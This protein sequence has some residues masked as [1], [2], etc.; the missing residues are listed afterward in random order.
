MPNCVSCGRELPPHG[1]PDNICPE[2]RAAA[3]VR[4]YEQARANRRVM[5]S[6]MLR[7][8]PVT[9]AIIGANILVYLAMTLSGVS[10]TDPQIP[11]LVK[12]GANNGVQ[13]LVSQPWRMLT[14]N[15]V[16]I[17]IIHIALNMWCLW[18]LGILA[19]RIFDRW[20]YFLTYTA[21]G[22]AGSLA[23]L[24]LHPHRYGAG[25]SGAIF[26]LAGALISAL[27]LGHLPIPPRALKSTLKSLV[28]FAGYNLFFGA[29]VPAIDNSAHMGGLVCG[30]ILGAVL[31]PHL[32]STPDER[33]SWRRFV[34]MA[35]TVILFGI[36]VFIRHSVVHAS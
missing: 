1:H 10:P 29:V 17:G 32:T 12:W 23:S 27:Y 34:F 22:I 33:N 19:E 24:G 8:I 15:Y 14:S 25:A 35:A 2:C 11:D 26:G 13:T 4:A 7:M 6:G 21:C 3:T 9:S 30:L 16:H 28:I 5:F 18:S 36:F 20:T 31:A